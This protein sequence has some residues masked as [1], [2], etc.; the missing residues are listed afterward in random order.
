MNDAWGWIFQ[1]VERF[2]VFLASVACRLCL[3]K[4][5]AAMY[6]AVIKENC[7]FYHFLWILVIILNPTGFFCLVLKNSSLI[8]KSENWMKQKTLLVKILCGTTRDCVVSSSLNI[9]GKHNKFMSFAKM[10]QFSI[11]KYTSQTRIKGHFHQDMLAEEGEGENY[12]KYRLTQQTL[13]QKT[14]CPVT[15]SLKKYLHHTCEH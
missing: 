11:T 6:F 12:S 5:F 2:I 1:N 3:L 4:L 8:G 7:S 10:L 15:P 13:P 14:N 9:D